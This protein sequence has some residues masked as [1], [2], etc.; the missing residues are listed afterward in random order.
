MSAR[1]WLEFGSVNEVAL[2]AIIFLAIIVFWALLPTEVKDVALGS[3]RR[4]GR[5][6]WLSLPAFMF[7]GWIGGW[8]LLLFVRVEDLHVMAPFDYQKLYRLIAVM[9]ILAALAAAAFFA[10]SALA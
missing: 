10:H 9:L 2:F 5:A 1:H 6:R 3:S 7:V 8:F 4:F